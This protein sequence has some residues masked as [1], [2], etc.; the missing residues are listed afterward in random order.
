MYCKSLIQVPELGI[1]VGDPIFVQPDLP[2]NQVKIEHYDTNI[3][4]SRKDV[5]PIQQREW[6]ELSAKKKAHSG[7]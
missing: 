2:N 5:Q 6:H 7:V 4:I 1:L 3:C